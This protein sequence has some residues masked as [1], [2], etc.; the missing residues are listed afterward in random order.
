MHMK[1]DLGDN[2]FANFHLAPKMVE[3]DE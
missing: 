1:Y 2:S 3:E